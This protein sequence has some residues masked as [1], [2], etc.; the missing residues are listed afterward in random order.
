MV[1]YDGVRQTTDNNITWRLSCWI[2]KATDI[3]LE[4]G[5]LVAFHD[6]SGYANAPARYVCT[7][8]AFL[9]TILPKEDL[10]CTSG[11]VRQTSSVIT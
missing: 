8:V 9:V 10:T 11:N 2:T 4:F 7:Y 3:H 5:I 1:K 6:S